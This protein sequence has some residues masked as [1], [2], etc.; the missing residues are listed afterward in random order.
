ME[1]LSQVM[2]PV[3][4]SLTLWC[5]YRCDVTDSLAIFEWDCDNPG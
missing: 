2:W 1:A 5:K 3:P 4:S